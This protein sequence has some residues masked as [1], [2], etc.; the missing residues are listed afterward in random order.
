MVL[1]SI[2]LRHA[3]CVSCW[4]V[5]SWGLPW[6]A[7][8]RFTAVEL[9]PEAARGTGPMSNPSDLQ[10][11]LALAAAEAGVELQFS[12]LHTS[13]E[14]F[15][16]AMLGVPRGGQDPR[17]EA[18]VVNLATHLE[19]LPDSTVLRSN[20]RDSFLRVSCGLRPPDSN[21]GRGF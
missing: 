20:P 12:V 15:D 18:L 3:K 16:P 1:V 4:P 17:E 2:A 9:P 8:G 5:P 21:P 19:T 6:Y 10:V 7:A 14:D 11:E 13:M